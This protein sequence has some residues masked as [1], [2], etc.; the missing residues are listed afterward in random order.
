MAQYSP[1]ELKKFYYVPEVTYGV[2]PPVATVANLTWGCDPVT[3]K[4][5]VNPNKE[6]HILAGSRSHGAVTKGGW[7]VG[8]TLEGLA[9]V[10][11]GTYDWF[12]LWAVYGMGSTSGLA[13]HLGSFT[14]QV[15]KTVGASNYYEFYNGCKI[16]KLS[17]S[18]DGPGKLVKFQA[19]VFCQWITQDTDKAI[20]GLQALTVG[21]DPAADITTAILTWTGVSQINIAAGGLTTWHPRKW[22]LTVDNH[23]ERVMGNI[24]G[25]DAATYSTTYALSEGAR[26]IIFTCELPYEGETYTAAKLASSAITAL[27]IPVDNETITLST[28]ELLVDGDD[29]PEYGHKLMDE[30]VRI[31]FQSL[32]IA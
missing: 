31:K 23:L 20:T 19:D 26:D 7:E 15:G 25:A 8:F 2:T 18:C 21:A 30:P 4:P 10:A 5:K 9:H 29:W 11:S 24:T 12:D 22:E 32:A 27:T 6:F 28:G 3:L 1:G 13:T 17:I 14:A 16:N